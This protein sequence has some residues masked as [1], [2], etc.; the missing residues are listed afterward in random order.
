MHTVC[1]HGQ[2]QLQHQGE[3]AKEESS[4]LATGKCLVIELLYNIPKLQLA[5]R[6]T[7]THLGT[8]LSDYDA[9]CSNRLSTIHLD[10]SPL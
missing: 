8:E 4:Q 5:H 7:A 2:G 6:Q 1:N 3:T 10:P 9:S